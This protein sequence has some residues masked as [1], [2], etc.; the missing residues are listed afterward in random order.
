MF[1]VHLRDTKSAGLCKYRTYYGTSCWIPHDFGI[2]GSSFARA[3]GPSRSLGLDWGPQRCS[4]SKSTPSGLSTPDECPARLVLSPAWISAR[5]TANGNSADKASVPGPPRLPR[6][7]SSP[8]LQAQFIEQLFAW[9][10]GKED[11]I[12]GV[13]WLSH[14]DWPYAHTK[15]ALQG[16]LDEAL[17]EHEPFMR[18]LTS[19]GLMY[20]DGAKKPGYDAMKNTLARYRRGEVRP[21]PSAEPR[22]RTVVLSNGGFEA[23]DLSEAANDV[24]G[25]KSW[26]TSNSGGNAIAVTKER[27]RGGP[28]SLRWH[29]IGWNVKD[30]K[31]VEDACTFIITRVAPRPGSSAIAVRLSGAVNTSAL[32]PKFQVSVI[33]A[34]SSFTKVKIDPSLRGGVAGWQTFDTFLELGA[35]GDTLFVA[36][37]VVGS[38]GVGAGK[39]SVYLDDLKLAYD[40]LP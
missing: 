26:L 4:L 34:N 25:P 13:S 23:G 33:L 15:Q 18:Y 1:E 19:L 16:F 28:H 40:A 29:P 10:C 5:P 39:G 14:I 27:A 12:L 31:T 36:F 11:R 22:Q 8:K 3:A 35:E 9:L 20:E 30:D 37:I 2:P 17:L 7:D 32:D 6:I 21:L 24:I 38:K